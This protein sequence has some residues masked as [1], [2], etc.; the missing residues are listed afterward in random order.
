MVKRD[1]SWA[2]LGVLALVIR[3]FAIQNPEA[4]DEIYSRK[5]FP[6]IRNVIDLTLG[7]LPFPSVYLFVATVFFVIGL[8]IYRFIHRE[9]WQAKSL[10]SIQA[11]SN[12]L[13]AIVFF[14]LVLWGFNYHRT[15][16][17]QQLSLN[18]KALNLEQL[19]SEIEITKRL[20]VQYRGRIKTD[21]LPISS[22]MEYRDLERLVRANM[23]EHLEI[24]GLN[25]TGKPRTKQ[26]PPDGFMRKM[27]ILGIYFPFT[28][29][30]YI[31]P[32]LHPLEQPFTVAHEMAHSYGVTDEGEAN[33]IAWVICT[34]SEDPLLRYSGHIRLLQYQMRDFY[35]M[36]PD[37]YK[38]W[39]RG[40]PIGIRNDLN[41]LRES[42]EAVKAFS[43]ELSRKSNDIFLKSQG[44]KAGVNSYQQL[45]MLAYSWRKRMNL[46][47]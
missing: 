40:L 3:Y 6:G 8:F 10:Y 19:K 14:F 35:R 22:I 17:F 26:F 34:N 47:D 18:P 37:D 41:S 23:N 4:T 2:I 15:P 16:I 29:E 43:N 46:Q 20:T 38:E 32:T 21:S 36:A 45:P 12:G 28:G 24:L 1:W 13:G 33:F 30:S 11:I 42:S 25:F 5:F 39:V 31:D 7:N 27:G 44:V 9:G